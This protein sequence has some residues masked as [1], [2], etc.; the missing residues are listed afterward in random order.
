MN[1]TT[2]CQTRVPIRTST[3]VLRPCSRCLALRQRSPAKTPS[4]PS[5]MQTAGVTQ[6]CG[7][8]SKKR[9]NSRKPET[10][11]S[12]SSPKKSPVLAWLGPSSLGASWRYAACCPKNEVIVVLEV[13]GT[14][15]IM[16]FF[17]VPI[18]WVHFLH[19]SQVIFARHAAA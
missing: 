1:G 6:S 10:R 17:A 11:S 19:H 2:L 13:K 4:S 7:P 5:A 15:N 16:G 3:S 14:E 18:C 8:V 12:L 9:L